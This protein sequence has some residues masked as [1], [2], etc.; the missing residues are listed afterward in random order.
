MLPV[1]AIKVRGGGGGYRNIYH[2]SKLEISDTD[3]DPLVQ[4]RIKQIMMRI[5]LDNSY[6]IHDF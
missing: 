6:F 5:C 3:F 4:E 1:S 2:I